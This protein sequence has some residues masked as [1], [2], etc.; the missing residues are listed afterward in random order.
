MIDAYLEDTSTG[1]LEY[2]GQFEDEEEF[3]GFDKL[4]NY[5]L[6]CVDWCIEH[7]KNVNPDTD[8]T[9][10]YIYNLYRGPRHAILKN[11]AENLLA[12]QS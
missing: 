7:L 2:F 8:E 9:V 12:K 3:F 4:V 1:S 10:H 11:L 6:S 5:H